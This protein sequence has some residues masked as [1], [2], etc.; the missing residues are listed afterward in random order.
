MLLSWK[1]WKGE[2]RREL[3]K[4]LTHKKNHWII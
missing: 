4:A 3:D 2:V 1:L